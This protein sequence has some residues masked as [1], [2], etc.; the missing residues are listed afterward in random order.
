MGIGR[1]ASAWWPLGGSVRTTHRWCKT[2]QLG[3]HGAQGT[4]MGALFPSPS[5]T[6]VLAL[7]V[8][9]YCIWFLLG[10]SGPSWPKWC[11]DVLWSL[12]LLLLLLLL[13][14][15]FFQRDR[16][17]GSRFQYTSIHL[18]ETFD[19]SLS[20]GHNGINLTNSWVGPWLCVQ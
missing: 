2:I 11:L 8:F 18:D 14:R 17:G 19:I 13:G 7:T 4:C 20:Y 12:L 15:L 10:N 1:E 3:A 9:G 6:P 5:R 16:T